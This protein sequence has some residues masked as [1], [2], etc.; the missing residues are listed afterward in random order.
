VTDF[1]YKSRN[2]EA[3]K[4]IFKKTGNRLSEIFKYLTYSM[5][6]VKRNDFI[7]ISGKAIANPIQNLTI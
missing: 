4:A 7:C 2:L 1:D 3:G 5:E 6:T